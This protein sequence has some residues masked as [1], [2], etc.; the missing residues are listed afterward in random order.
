MAK[1]SRAERPTKS[2]E[3]ELTPEE[4]AQV[5]DARCEV[6]ND[7]LDETA[8]AWMRVFSQRADGLE[9]GDVQALTRQQVDALL[10]ARSAARRA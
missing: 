1:K 6:N 2:T 8:M 3:Y 10:D 7:H 5:A 4:R 9:R